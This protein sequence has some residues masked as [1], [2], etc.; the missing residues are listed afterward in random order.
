VIL[1]IIGISSTF[2]FGSLLSKANEK[3]IVTFL[4]VIIFTMVIIQGGTTFDDQP[5]GKWS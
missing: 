2:L 1:V 3:N 4:S 5:I